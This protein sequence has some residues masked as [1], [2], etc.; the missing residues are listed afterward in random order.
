VESVVIRPKYPAVWLKGYFF[1]LPVRVSK[2]RAAVHL[3]ASI[4]TPSWPS[5]TRTL[6]H[7][8]R[9]KLDRALDLQEKV[10]LE[11]AER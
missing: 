6:K 5:P 10:H 4:P 9:N 8:Q 11:R 1:Y 2:G 3:D 7:E